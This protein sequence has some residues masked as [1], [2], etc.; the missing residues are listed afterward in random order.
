MLFVD[1][2]RRRAGRCRLAFSPSFPSLP[3]LHLS[4]VVGEAMAIS[5]ILSTRRCSGFGRHHGFS[6]QI[7][8][9]SA[10]SGA[11]L[12]ARTISATSPCL[13]AT[14]DAA[15]LP[16]SAPAPPAA[17]GVVP[18]MQ[19]GCR[20]PCSSGAA[21]SPFHSPCRLG[22]KGAM[23]EE[24]AHGGGRREQV[25]FTPPK[26]ARSATELPRPMPAILASSCSSTGPPMALP[27]RPAAGSLASSDGHHSA[28]SF[29]STCVHSHSSLAAPPA[30]CAVHSMRGE[31]LLL[32]GRRVHK[33]DCA[34]QYAGVV[35]LRLR[36]ARDAVRRLCAC[37]TASAI[38]S[39]W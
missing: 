9:P 30:A 12:A 31:V 38:S 19:L 20:S 10:R 34:S 2:P 39:H 26:E 37:S 15:M 5:K 28:L 25:Q 6:C 7:Q 29:L 3:S 21:F 8:P 18:Q 27:R 32:D 13:T 24:R 23:P 36:D 11:Q 22:R 33:K 4:R 16:S 14:R 35:V 17:Q 1:L